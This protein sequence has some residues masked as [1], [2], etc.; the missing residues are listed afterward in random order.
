MANYDSMIRWEIDGHA[1]ASLRIKVLV[2]HRTRLAEFDYICSAD[3]AALLLL[4]GRALVG[5]VVGAHGRARR[6]WLLAWACEVLALLGVHLGL[7]RFE[8]DY[9]GAFWGSRGILYLDWRSSHLFVLLSGVM[10]IFGSCVTLVLILLSWYWFIL[11]IEKLDLLDSR[12]WRDWPITCDSG[13]RG[14]NRESEVL[15]AWAAT[16]ATFLWLNQLREVVL[17][18]WQ[19]DLI[20]IYLG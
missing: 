15:A 11:Q 1:V 12:W 5:N 17:G 3:H 4:L 20:W 6:R 2:H 9:F 13:A 10:M 16:L 7:A 18:C 19:L 8:F 14:P